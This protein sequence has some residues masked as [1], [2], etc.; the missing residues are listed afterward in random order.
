MRRFL[1]LIP[2]VVLAGSFV[3][4]VPAA[5]KDKD[6]YPLKVGN[7][8]QY[9]MGESRFYVIAAATEKIGGVECTR[10]DSRTRLLPKDKAKSSDKTGVVSYE[11]V[12]V[13]ADGVARYSF[14]GKKAAPPIVFLKFPVKAGTTWKIES[15]VAGQLFKG[16]FKLGEAKK[17]T[18]PAGTYQAV[19]VTG[20]DMNVNGEKLSVTYWFAEGVGMIQQEAELAGQK[21][22]IVLEKFEKG[23]ESEK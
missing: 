7:T 17:V 3:P 6:Y 8:W 1:L 20:K 16:V 9:R 4:H 2:A 5:D 23:K 21:I 11:H 22:K 12:A 19:T 14:E 13:T 15:K 10:L 18:V